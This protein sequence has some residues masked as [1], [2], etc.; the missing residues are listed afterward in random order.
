MDGVGGGTTWRMTIF[1]ISM[2]P[3]CAAGSA[4][5]GALACGLRKRKTAIVSGWLVLCVD[6]QVVRY[7]EMKAHR[8]HEEGRKNA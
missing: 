1:F 8:T 7:A 6:F 3:W 5:R 2:P 4:D